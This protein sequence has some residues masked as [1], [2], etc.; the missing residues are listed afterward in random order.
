M[1]KY[2]LKIFHELPDRM[3]RSFDAL[4]TDEFTIRIFVALSY[5][6]PI[7]ILTNYWE[8]ILG[9]M[10]QRLNGFRMFDLTLLCCSC[11]SATVVMKDLSIERLFNFYCM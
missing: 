9:C 11:L 1:L 3:A 8:N 4:F 5:M 10:I 2:K 7:L 6:K